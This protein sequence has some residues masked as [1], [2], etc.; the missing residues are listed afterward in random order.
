MTKLR[1]RRLQPQFWLVEWTL[2]DGKGFGVGAPTFDFAKQLIQH[3]SVLNAARTGS[4]LQDPL[5]VG[6]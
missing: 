1:C 5:A 3:P 2:A 4:A 6:D